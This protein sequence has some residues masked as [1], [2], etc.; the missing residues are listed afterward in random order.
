M[1]SGS[2]VRGV[3]ASFFYVERGNEG[4]AVVYIDDGDRAEEY[5]QMYG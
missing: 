5:I 4:G 1:L 3:F 2:C